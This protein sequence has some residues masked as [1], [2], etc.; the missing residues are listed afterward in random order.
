[1]D[2]GKLVMSIL[3]LIDVSPLVI[4]FTLRTF[5]PS[6]SFSQISVFVTLLGTSSN[7]RDGKIDTSCS[8]S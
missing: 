8:A 4:L 7:S 1:M 6:I 2:G 3:S 5:T